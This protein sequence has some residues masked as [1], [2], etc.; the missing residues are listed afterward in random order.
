[1]SRAHQGRGCIDCIQLWLLTFRSLCLMGT[2]SHIQGCSLPGMRQTNSSADNNYGTWTA[3]FDSSY[4]LTIYTR[5]GDDRITEKQ[6]VLRGN[7]KRYE[8]GRRGNPKKKKRGGGV[9]GRG[10]AGMTTVYEYDGG[11]DATAKCRD[12]VYRDRIISDYRQHMAPGRVAPRKLS[13]PVTTPRDQARWNLQGG[14]GWTRGL[15]G[16]FYVCF[17]SSFLFLFLC[18][19]IFSSFMISQTEW[20]VWWST[21]SRRA[22]TGRLYGKGNKGKERQLDNGEEENGGIRAKGKKNSHSNRRQLSKCGFVSFFSLSSFYKKIMY[23]RGVR[24]RVWSGSQKR[25]HTNKQA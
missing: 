20:G 14:N 2:L 13:G 24:V 7:R 23:I 10:E 12:R 19:L 25:T 4:Y 21:N 3:T 5:Q 16:V 9:R 11:A 22:V 6:Y 8:Y 15:F 1:M 17:Y 18:D